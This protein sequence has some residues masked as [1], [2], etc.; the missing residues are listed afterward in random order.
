M[1]H[2]GD[3]VA[4]GLRFAFVVGRFNDFISE[5][6]L[7]GGLD[8]CRRHGMDMGECEIA[9][10]PGMFEAPLVAKKLAATGRFDA[11]ICL[12]AVIRGGT[13]HFDF[14]AGQA[15]NGL[16]RAALDTEVPVIF[17]VL[18]TDTIEQCIERSGT[19]MGNKGAEAVLAAI[20]T[21]N[22]LKVLADGRGQ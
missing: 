15:A 8:T 16:T 10:V 20:E 17:G 22:L 7:Q 3:M 2:E 9:W 21:A 1:V 18:T 11:V 14:V 5:R 4:T 6:L 12:G 19:K 13:A